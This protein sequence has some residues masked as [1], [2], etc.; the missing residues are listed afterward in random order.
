MIKVEKQANGKKIEF[1]F[2]VD[3]NGDILYKVPGVLENELNKNGFFRARKL[4]E[5]FQA[6]EFNVKRK[7]LGN[8]IAGVK[9]EKEH[10]EYLKSKIEEA[11]KQKELAE[12]KEWDE[13]LNGN[14]KIKVYYHDGE[15][16]SAYIVFGKEAKLLEKLGLA[17]Y[18]EGWGTKVEEEVIEALGEKFTYE[19]ARNFA[20]QKTK[21]QEAK[22]KEQ[23]AKRKAEIE[24]KI[25][26]AKETGKPVELRRWV[27][28]C[29]D[30]K[31][32]C[33]IDHVVEYVTPDGNTIIVRYHT[34]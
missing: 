28:S 1:V 13:L 22:R 7:I 10:Y 3:K 19:Q 9:L 23:E 33:D 25:Q 18:I 6:V 24:A 12:Q 14:K 31:E 4:N 34:W 11:E 16:L 5:K 32:D 20:Q 27:E 30:P 2:D 8:V 17:R 29:N 21:E 15:Y 26:E